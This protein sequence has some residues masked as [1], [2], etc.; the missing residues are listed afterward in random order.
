MRR[1]QKRWFT[2][3]CV[4]VV[5]AAL[6]WFFWPRDTKA[7]DPKGTD[8]EKV[9]TTQP[10]DKNTTPPKDDT[11]A[12]RQPTLDEKKALEV[13][14]SGMNLL[15]ANRFIEARDNISKA[16]LS[17][18]LDAATAAEARDTATQLA[19]MTIFLRTAYKNDPYCGYV[20]V[21]S[22][23]TLIK[24]VREQKL[25]VSYRALMRINSIS[26]ASKLQ[27]GQRIKLL[28]GPCH[29]IIYKSRF[30]M[31]LYLHR[32][33]LPR[34]FLKRV[35]VGLGKNNSTPTGLW[36]VAQG[37]KLQHTD[38]YPSPNSRFKGVKKY[39]DPDYAF[40]NKGLWIG[41]EG[42]DKNTKGL[43]D[44]GLH[45]TNAPDSIGKAESEGCI[46]LRD[47]DIDLVFALLFEKMSAVEIR[48]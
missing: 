37:E 35:P 5:A 17:G 47:E 28:I 1:E 19:D 7:K 32:Q 39:G 31:D 6:A 3:L 13:Y 40:G 29:A 24:I 2:A 12:A 41:L 8:G 43:N 30:V 9:A 26:D 25:Y 44:Y 4:L 21:K 22:G 46:R 14:R 34:V 42:I 36:R 38:W 11:R 27:A 15:K 48:P 20:F 10:A 33:G 18:S 45:S 16:L 23:D